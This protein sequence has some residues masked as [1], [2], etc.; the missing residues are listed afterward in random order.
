MF[1]EFI[2]DFKKIDLSGIYLKG[3]DEKQT[4][5]NLNIK[6]DINQACW[7]PVGSGEPGKTFVFSLSCT[8]SARVFI[9]EVVPYLQKYGNTNF[10]TFVNAVHNEYDAYYWLMYS[11]IKPEYR[12]K[13]I[14]AHFKLFH[15]IGNR[16]N[17]IRDEIIEKV[18]SSLTA[19]EKLNGEEIN[20]TA[21]VF[22]SIA[23]SMVLADNYGIKMTPYFA[24]L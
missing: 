2:G 20:P 16:I 13:Y 11:Q 22:G 5:S 12:G 6:R 14:A 15:S 8:D 7:F 21:V 10:C 23:Y 9:E 1:R 3:V 17:S 18:L 4:A 24:Y 19:E